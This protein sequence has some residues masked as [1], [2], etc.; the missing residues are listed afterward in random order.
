MI[1]WTF[2]AIV[3]NNFDKLRKRHLHKFYFQH[4]M[5]ITN[6]LTFKYRKKIL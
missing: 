6:I 1:D 3:N 2:Q 5:G 4:M